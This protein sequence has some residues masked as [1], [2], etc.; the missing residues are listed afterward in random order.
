MFH[1]IQCFLRAT[2]M[3]KIPADDLSRTVSVANA[4]QAHEPTRILVP[5][6]R[7]F[8]GVEFSDVSPGCVAGISR[9]SYRAPMTLLISA[10]LPPHWERA[11]L[12]QRILP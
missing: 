6:F 4:E 5:V 2:T 10:V 7:H 12:Y 1:R 11:R 3:R 8:S 9:F